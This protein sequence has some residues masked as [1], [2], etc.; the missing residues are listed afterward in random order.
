LSDTTVREATFAALR[1]AGAT[2]VF[3]NPGSTELPMFRD[4]PADFRYVLGLQESAATAMADGWAQAAHRPAV[5]NLHSAAGVGHAMGALFTAFRNRS[6]LVVVA[7]QQAR[8][9]LAG[10]PYLLSEQPEQLPAPYVKWSREPARAQ[11]V[12]AA[13]ARACHLA[14]APP[15]G[16]VLVSVPADDWDRPAALPDT[17]AV[18]TAVRGDPARLRAIGEAL[19]AARRPAFVVGAAADQERAIPAVRALAES[20][21]AAVWVAPMA[22]RCGFPERHPLFAGFLPPVRRQLADH[23]AGHDLVLVF[24]APVFTYHVEDEGPVLPPGTELVQITDDPRTA[25]WTPVGTALVSG[26]GPAARELLLFPPLRP[27]PEP[28]PRTRPERVAAAG[29]LTEEFLVQTLADVRPPGCV[30]VEEAPGTRPVMCERLPNEGPESFYT[31][32]SGGLGFGLP[33]A[34]GI[35]LAR[36]RERVLAVIGDGAA[37][38]SIQALW[39]AVELGVRLA[40]LVVNNGSYATV[41]RFARRFGVEKP[42]GTALPGLDF[43]ALAAAQGCAA[44]RVR[45]PGALPAALRTALAA[46]G[47]HVLEVV[48]GA[49]S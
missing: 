24:G 18:S 9:L 36:P 4:F 16:P 20:H 41:D 21:R 39:T 28:P 40:V 3:G 1:D 33:A 27:R 11:D 46:D 8:S 49:L 7:G 23:L 12:P 42:P 47:P 17:R 31:T 15:Q 2:T 5:V 22:G 19:A 48:V 45:D 35:A 14:T 44:A 38:Y 32:G 26:T 25:A 37:M 30:L 29:G 13:I 6:P 10:E 34:V 43:A